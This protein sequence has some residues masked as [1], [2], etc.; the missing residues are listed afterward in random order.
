[1]YRITSENQKSG[2]DQVLPIARDVMAHF[3]EVVR[4]HSQDA[5]IL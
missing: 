2:Q 3:I 1:M 5:A 4:E